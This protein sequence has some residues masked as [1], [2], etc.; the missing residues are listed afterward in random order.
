MTKRFLPLLALL[1]LLAPAAQAEKTVYVSDRLEVP[2]YDLAG[3][4]GTVVR[5]VSVGDPL[6]VVQRDGELVQVRAPGGELGWIALELI[7]AE[8]PPRVRLMEL[9]AERAELRAELREAQGKLSA[10]GVSGVASPVPAME[11]ELTALREENAA[12]RGRIESASA[13]LSGRALPGGDAAADWR[14]WALW[15]AGLFA[16]GF[17]AGFLFHRYRHCR[18]HGGFRITLG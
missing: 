13:A 6:E 7:A 17:L 2:L 3:E 14:D 15:V 4:E 8:K 18:S 12:L 5:H 16:V 1:Y 9:E 10:A 11:D